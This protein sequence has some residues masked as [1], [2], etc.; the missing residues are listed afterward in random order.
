MPS[1][2]ASSAVSRDDRFR[3]VVRLLARGVLRGIE[4]E[5]RR[6]LDD[7]IHHPKLTSVVLTAAA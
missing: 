2:S 6:R 1:K 3:T 4:V 5:Q 7:R